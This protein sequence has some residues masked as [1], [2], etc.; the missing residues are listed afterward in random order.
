MI[1]EPITPVARTVSDYLPLTRRQ[2]LAGAAVAGTFLLA[3]CLATGERPDEPTLPIEPEYGGW[4]DGVGT[5]QGTLDYRGREAVEIDVG[6]PG[7]LGYFKF[8][9]VAVAVSPGTTVT[10][11]WTGK[12]GGHDVVADNGAFASG[13]LVTT[14][15]HT[16]SHTF[17]APGVY[18]YF[19]TPHRAMGMRGA[20]FVALEG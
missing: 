8:A 6:A 16:F 12:G 9:P 10:W 11:R 13:D 5:Y 2:Y 18:K 7:D 1:P 19:C 20:V 14:A 17:D 3:G 15:D 4:F